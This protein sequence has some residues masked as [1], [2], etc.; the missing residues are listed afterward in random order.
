MLTKMA[1]CKLLLG[2]LA[3][4]IALPSFA[5]TKENKPIRHTIR[6][7]GAQ[8]KAKISPSIVS[9]KPNKNN[10]IIIRNTTSRDRGINLEF[11]PNINVKI[12]KNEFIESTGNY[13]L[14]GD[15]GEASLM[16]KPIKAVKV[17]VKS[18][19]T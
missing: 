3:L 4:C 5:S 10:L 18:E 11:I 13:Y 12:E 1:R 17:K 19:D 6:I 2:C 8:N 9:L 16:I 15:K 7:S 14:V